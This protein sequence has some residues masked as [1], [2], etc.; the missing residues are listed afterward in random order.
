MLRQTLES[1]GRVRRWAGVVLL[2]SALAALGGVVGRLALRASAKTPS[3]SSGMLAEPI[4]LH[5]VGDFSHPEAGFPMPESAGPFRRVAVMQYDVAGRDISAGYDLVPEDGRSLPVFATLY[6]YP[7]RSGSDLDAG[8]EAIVRDVAACHGGR[9]PAFRRN[10]FVSDRKFDAR[11]AGFDFEEPWGGLK[12]SIPLHSYLL[13]YQWSGWWVKWR[14]TTPAPV[15][16]TRIRAIV[17]LTESLLP[18]ER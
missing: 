14:A 6:V 4:E 5:P 13:L 15:D 11:Y 16:D 17:E 2:G 12:E 7:V 1:K 9:L 10:V 8:F 18:P 3:T